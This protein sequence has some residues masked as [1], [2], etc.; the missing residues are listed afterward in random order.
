MIVSNRCE[1]LTQ[2]GGT[3]ARIGLR[4]ELIKAGSK[5]IP[6]S[7]VS[8]AMVETLKR[9]LK[10]RLDFQ[11]YVRS[12]QII[13]IDECFVA[14][15]KIGLKNIENIKPGDFV[16][17]FNHN[18]NKIESKKVLAVSKKENYDKLIL[19]KYLDDFIVCTQNHPIFVIG[20]GY[21]NAKDLTNE[22]EILLQGMQQVVG[23][24]SK[25]Q[26][27][28]SY[29]INWILFLFKRLCTGLSNKNE[30]AKSCVKMFSLRE[31][32]RNKISRS[33]FRYAAS[34]YEW[35]KSILLL[36]LQRFI[37]CANAFRK[38]EEKQ[39]IIQRGDT[40]KNVRYIETDR[41][42]T[43]NSRGE[44]T[45]NDRTTK[46]IIRR[47]WRWV[48]SR[49]DNYNRKR[50]FTTSFQ[51]RYWEPN[52]E[53][54]NRNKWRFP[55]LFN[56]KKEGRKK[57]KSFRIERIQSVDILESAD[58]TRLTGC[59]VGNYV[60]NLEVEDN[61]NYFANG[62]LVHNCHLCCF[63]DLFTY[64]SPDCIVM[65]F[66]A[67][68]IRFGKMPE[69]ADYFTSLVQGPAISNLISDGFL[70]RPEYYG[71]PIDLAAVRI[72]GGE[73]E[74]TDLQKIYTS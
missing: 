32:F 74:E 33:L 49:I 48:V 40:E 58:I 61:N 14:G 60:Y 69:L 18:T 57:E 68:P 23:R 24:K 42:Q 26:R 16:D 71:V 3:F 66:T 43:Y 37:F 39:S 47:T 53:N 31:N 38:N 64:I 65:G 55:L 59:D 44:W 36:N 45:R 13:I 50:L 62:V 4:Y 70:S 56:R 72:K 22:D 41:S 63:N 1:L 12:L 5:S 28:K 25:Q 7:P 30:T 67:T 6:T 29:K 10:T 51:N 11:M 8:I 34:F 2:T 46:N 20:K 35:K 52:E 21:V 27:S 15:T 17:S 19:L 9:R 54:S 73:F